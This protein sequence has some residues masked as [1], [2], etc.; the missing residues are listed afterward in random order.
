MELNLIVL[1]SPDPEKLAKFYEALLGRSLPKHRH[2]KGP[3]HFGTELGKVVFEIYPQRD[4]SDLTTCLRFGLAVPDFDQVFVMVEASGGK[5]VSP[6]KDSE[7]GRRMVID[8]PDGHRIE[9]T[10]AS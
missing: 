5:I 9:I 7:W 2:G 6:P 1:R 10:A 3:E 4:E 8:D